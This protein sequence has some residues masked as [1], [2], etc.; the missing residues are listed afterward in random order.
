MKALG[1]GWRR[2]IRFR[3]IEVLEGR[4]GGHHLRLH[5]RAALRAEVIGADALHLALSDTD[6]WAAACVVF[7]ARGPRPTP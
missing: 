1:T 5:G 2:G 6:T 3:D 7:E 4:G